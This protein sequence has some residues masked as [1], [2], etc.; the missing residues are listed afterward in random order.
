MLLVE[1]PWAGR[2]WAL[3]FL[4]VLAPS[5][6]YAQAQQRR[7]KTLLDWGR[8]MLRCCMALV[9]PTPDCGGSRQ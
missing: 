3:P 6:R 2:V 8:Q 5:Q 7:Y 1:I 9:A 4:S